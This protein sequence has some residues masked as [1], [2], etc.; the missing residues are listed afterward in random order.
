MI[1][2]VPTETFPGEHRVAL[3]PDTVH[4]LV[5]KG[6]EVAIETG[7]GAAAG[8]ADDLYVSRGAQVVPAADLFERSQVVLQVR[9]FGANPHGAPALEYLRADHIVIGFADALDRSDRISALARRG[10]TLLSMELMPRISRAQSMD[11]LS[12][13]ATIAGYKSVLMAA[14]LLPRMFPLL[15]TAAGTLTPAKVLV[16][17]AGVAGLQAIATAKRL[18]AS[19]SAYDA[20]AAVKDQ[21]NSLGADFVDLGIDTG[22]SEDEGGYATAHDYTFYERQ[23]SALATVIADADVVVSTAAI[24]GQPAPLL[25]TRHAVESMKAGSV[26]I[27]LAAERGGNCEITEP[28]SDVELEGVTVCGPLN[29]PATIPAHASQMYAHNIATFLLHLVDDD[30]QLQLNV[31]DEITAGTLVARAG[32]IVHERV[33]QVQGPAN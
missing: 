25:I 23:R 18:G 13:M 2:G 32:T 11:A 16:L 6:L 17:G 20:R 30:G 14:G 24:P 4:T 26:I 3:V 9:T 12:S 8:F 33:L 15:M 29:L 10:V 1:V 5:D 19:V 27:D 7:A 21:I 22:D 31:E 28:G